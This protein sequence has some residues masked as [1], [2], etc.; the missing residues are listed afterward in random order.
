MVNFLFRI[1]YIPI[2]GFNQITYNNKQLIIS[3]IIIFINK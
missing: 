3:E 1:S 2:K